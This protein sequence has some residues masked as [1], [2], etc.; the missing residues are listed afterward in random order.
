MRKNFKK[1]VA[2][3]LALTMVIAGIGAYFTGTDKKSDS[4][5]IGQVEVELT[6]ADNLYS[7]EKLTPRE[8]YTFTRAVHNIGINDAYVFMTVTMPYEAANL[9]DE[10]G[11]TIFEDVDTQL[12]KYGTNGV[13]GVASQWKLV[14]AGKY[15]DIDIEEL[16]GS[17]IHEL[18]DEFG[19]ID[20]VGETITYVYG[21][22]GD[23]ADGSL[24]ALSADETTEDLFD[25]VKFANVADWNMEATE[26]IIKTRAFAIQTLNVLETTYMEGNNMDGSEVVNTVW[27]VINNAAVSDGEVSTPS[28]FIPV[29][30]VDQ[31][32]NDLDA[33]S[34]LITGAEKNELLDALE[35]QGLADP[36]DVDYLIDVKSDDFE[37][38]ADTTFDMSGIAQE[39][40]TVIILHYNEANQEWEYITEDTVDGNLTVGGDFQSFSPVA[41]IIIPKEEVQYEMVEK[42]IIVL[43]PNGDRMNKNS[44]E[45]YTDGWEALGTT[46]ENGEAVIEFPLNTEF[47]YFVFGSSNFDVTPQ[48]KMTI[49]E[50]TPDTITFQYTDLDEY[51]IKIVDTNGV[52]LSENIDIMADTSVGDIELGYRKD[53]GYYR[54][55]YDDLAVG[56][57]ITITGLAGVTLT[58]D[59]VIEANK[60]YYTAVVEPWET[61]TVTFR[62]VDDAT[63]DEMDYFCLEIDGKEVELES[64][65]SISYL[66]GSTHEI[67]ACEDCFEGY[68]LDEEE[69]TADGDM[70]MTIFVS[71]SGSSDVETYDIELRVL[72]YGGEAYSYDL[73]FAGTE[74]QNVS[75]N[76]DG[77]CDEDGYVEFT[78]VPAGEYQVII[79]G[80]YPED[81]DPSRRE[82]FVIVD[83]S[84]QYDIK[85]SQVEFFTSRRDGLGMMFYMNSSDAPV[86][87]GEVRIQSVNVWREA[88]SA[89]IVESSAVVNGVVDITVTTDDEGW[90]YASIT[91]GV[92]LISHGEYSSVV[93][94]NNTVSPEIQDYEVW[95]YADIEAEMVEHKLIIKDQD[96]NRISKA[97]Y[98]IGYDGDDAMG[99][100]D[101]N[102]EAIVQLPL[103]Q[104][105]SIAIY[106][107]DAYGDPDEYIMF[108]SIEKLTEDTSYEI[109]FPDDM[110]S[111][112]WF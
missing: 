56:D 4:Y 42:K 17:G 96:G 6:G 7:V 33:T 92:Y 46:D 18:S 93:E 49:T 101:E 77:T 30:A 54:F 55:A 58:E 73:I 91:N 60:P 95:L 40:D 98:E 44:Y 111:V 79:F 74:E 90:A 84:G 62:F 45:M 15:A 89:A 51:C 12:F 8:E 102:G 57:T 68:T 48:G 26:G 59:V 38:L 65:D 35:N 85:L 3:G 109:V 86:I 105:L 52:V 94:I 32:G 75:Y 27:S 87:E 99:L 104:H 78:G 53:N 67:Y 11:H 106:T 5:T 80:S 76:M 43:A 13:A 97:Y 61:A 110:N 83:H 41:I 108:G 16:A 71:G 63:G 29:T 10:Y 9:H 39:G 64:G 14:D 19:A 72:D 69:F 36:D 23:N 28:T 24:K 107:S 25:T 2:L 50:E 34:S 22:I 31:N 88:T 81:R 47:N 82:A 21:Y 70:E 66:K 112:D 100:T 20:T 103:N 1:V 37:D